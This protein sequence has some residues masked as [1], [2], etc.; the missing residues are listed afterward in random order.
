MVDRWA[1]ATGEAQA[2]AFEGA[3]AVRQVEIGLASFVSS[4]F[5]LTVCSF[6]ISILADRRFPRWLGYLGLVSGIGSLAAGVAQAH[7]GF[8]PVAMTLSMTASTFL[9]VWVLGV[10]IVMWRLGRK[11][12]DA[13]VTR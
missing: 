8:A 1:A 12:Q 13:S 10:G 11:L 5:G 6:G 9:L 2:R 4:L 3:F 7:T